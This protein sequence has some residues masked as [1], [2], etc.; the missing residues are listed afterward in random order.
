[1]EGGGGAVYESFLGREK[2]GVGGTPT[3]SVGRGKSPSLLQRGEEPPERQNA[4]HKG[5]MSMGQLSSP[6]IGEK[7]RNSL[8]LYFRTPPLGQNALLK[9]WGRATESSPGEG[10]RQNDGENKNS[11]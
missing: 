10:Q 11:V 5:L 2:T 3:H 8:H 9:K 1:L 6:C 4:Q 7:D